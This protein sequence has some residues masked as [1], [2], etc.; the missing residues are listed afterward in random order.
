MDRETP[1]WLG[2]GSLNTTVV[3]Y[4]RMKQGQRNVSTN[5]STNNDLVLREIYQLL[6]RHKEELSNIDRVKEP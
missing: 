4:V 5:T 6:D 1:E 2:F 3:Q